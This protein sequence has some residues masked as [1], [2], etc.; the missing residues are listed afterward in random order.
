MRT[1]LP[2][3]TVRYKYKG[4]GVVYYKSKAKR[5][6]ERAKPDDPRAVRF[7]AK[8]FLPLPLVEDEQREFPETRPDSEAVRHKML[9]HCD[10]CKRPAALKIKQAA[11]RRG[12]SS[13]LDR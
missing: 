12:W 1:V 5:K 6:Y 13:L 3:G 10:V 2:D 4:H 8:W 9:C 7:H 11:L